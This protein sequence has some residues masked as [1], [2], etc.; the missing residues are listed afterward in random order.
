MFSC[1]TRVCNSSGQGFVAAAQRVE[2]GAPVEMHFAALRR[3]RS[4][5]VQQGQR[6]GES[7]L[8]RQHHAAIEQGL[9]RVRLA[10]QHGAEIGQG[11]VQVLQLVFQLAT[12][13][14]HAV[15]ARRQQDAAVQ[16]HQRLI[17]PLQMA[18]QHGQPE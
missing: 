8:L 13:L 9:H 2:H 6:L 3:Q 15:L 17:R 18:Q 1:P 4:A 7:V 12:L 11:A 16:G 14:Q 10:R 5:P